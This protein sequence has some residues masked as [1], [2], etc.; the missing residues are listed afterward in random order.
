M[1]RRHT[2]L[3][4]AKTE[5]D[6]ESIP[7]TPELYT[8]EWC[9]FLP[10]LFDVELR[11]DMFT[12][13][14]GPRAVLLGNGLERV[15]LERGKLKFVGTSE[16]FATVAIRLPTG[17]IRIIW[18][19]TD[20]VIEFKYLLT[21]TSYV[22][23]NT[24]PQFENLPSPSFIDCL[25]PRTSL[26]T[27]RHADENYAMRT[28]GDYPLIVV[29]QRE[30]L[31]LYLAQL[32]DNP[33]LFRENALPNEGVTTDLTFSP[34]TPLHEPP[35]IEEDDTD[36]A[37]EIAAVEHVWDHWFERDSGAVESVHE[38]NSGAEMS[39]QPA[40]EGYEGDESNSRSSESNE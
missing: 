5:R 28:L 36:R 35:N 34:R 38:Q 9:I 15:S 33:I 20:L 32:R 11:R 3:E 16:T 30:Y 1:A 27:L 12:V 8:V 40:L 18:F 21:S 29:P 31:L 7:R 26:L 24:E 17:L 23:W 37:L 13:E 19:G 2:L 14:V 6:Y 39:P 22:R 25:G 10:P 4:E